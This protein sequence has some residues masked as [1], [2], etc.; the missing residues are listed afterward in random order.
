M[1]KQKKHLKYF[2]KRKKESEVYQ[3]L[4][5]SS[6]NNSSEL[7]HGYILY[8]VSCSGK[9]Y[10]LKKAQ[11]AFPD[12]VY[13]D[14]DKAKYWLDD[15]PVEIKSTF[16]KWFDEWS[17]RCDQSCVELVDHINAASEQCRYTQ[18]LLTRAC[19]NRIPFISTCGNLP[20][21]DTE[22][23][24]FLFKCFNVKITS[25]LILPTREDLIERVYKRGPKRIA[26][27]DELFQILD[28]YVRKK[29]RFD[30][31]IVDNRDTDAFIKIIGLTAEGERSE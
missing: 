16:Y 12:L 13:I 11:L 1:T 3:Q 10:T 19:F 17:T 20:L 23:F 22:Y 21:S 26:M 28:F 7:L 6:R 18:I 27:L 8:G 31:V 2:F 5:R 9:S 14:M 15:P 30:R 24:T 29:E 25:V 4:C